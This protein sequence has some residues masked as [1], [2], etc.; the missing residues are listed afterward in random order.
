MYSEELETRL[1]LAE[2]KIK[3]FSGNDKNLGTEDIKTPSK[4]RTKLKFITSSGGKK[5]HIQS[6]TEK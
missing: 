5:N 2:E 3:Y 6:S 4:I 1:M